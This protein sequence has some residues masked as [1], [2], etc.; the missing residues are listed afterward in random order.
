LQ[1]EERISRENY[2]FL[3][4]DNYY[5]SGVFADIIS[6]ESLK[7]QKHPSLLEKER[8][9]ANKRAVFRDALK[10]ARKSLFNQF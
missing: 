2:G 9:E 3:F 4:K 6:R 8:D 1:A 5:L 7:T 10:L